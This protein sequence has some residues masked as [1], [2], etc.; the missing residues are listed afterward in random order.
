MDHKDL[1][2]IQSGD[3][4]QSGVVFKR[5][6]EKVKRIKFFMKTL[7]FNIEVLYSHSSHYWQHS[8]TF[9]FTV[10]NQSGQWPIIWS[11]IFNILKSSNAHPDIF[12]QCLASVRILSRNKSNLNHA[13]VD[14]FD[15]LLNIANIGTHNVECSSEVSVEALKCLCNLVFQSEKCQ[16]MCLKNASIEGIVKRLRT[17]KWVHWTVKIFRH[18]LLPN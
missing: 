17:Y 1:E 6:V 9:D 5:F 4:E 3:V 11:S 16:A 13:T 15:C 8:Q 7:I 12:P 2:I 10:F 14:Q 18:S